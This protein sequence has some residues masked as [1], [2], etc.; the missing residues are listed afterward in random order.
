MKGFP[1]AKFAYFSKCSQKVDIS[2]VYTL[3]FSEQ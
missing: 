2:K 1:K 3:G